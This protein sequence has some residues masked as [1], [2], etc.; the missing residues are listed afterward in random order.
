MIDQRNVPPDCIPTP[1][2]IDRYRGK[3]SDAYKYFTN[4]VRGHRDLHWYSIY[5]Q[6][7]PIVELPDVRT[8]LEFGGGRNLT[9][10]ICRYYGIEH[11][12]VD[13][14]DRFY[15]DYV[16]TINDFEKDGCMYDLVCSFQTLEHN[17]LEEQKKLI[18]NMKRFT[19]KYL[20]VSLPYSGGWFSFALNVKLPKINIA[21]M[22]YITLFGLGGR[23]IN[24][25]PFRKLSASKRYSPHWWEVGRPGVPKRRIIKMYEDCG[26]KLLDSRHSPLFPHHYFLLFEKNES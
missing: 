11:Y 12:S 24:D 7:L 4:D 9:R 23:R 18:E 26:L 10:T 2:P 8:V 22:K 20:Y 5:L 1:N 16:S 25:E 15:T 3:D 14:S 6:A 21:F 13:V 19:K 17:P